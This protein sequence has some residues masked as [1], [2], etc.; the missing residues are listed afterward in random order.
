MIAN[1]TKL[2][3]RDVLNAYNAQHKGMT[4]TIEAL[5]EVPK[6]SPLHLLERPLQLVSL[7]YLLKERK[8]KLVRSRSAWERRQ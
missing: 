4:I 1:T 3:R 5:K 7:S 6:K 8:K 2:I